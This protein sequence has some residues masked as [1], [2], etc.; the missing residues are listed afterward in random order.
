MNPLQ[1]DGLRAQRYL[2]ALETIGISGVPK[3]TIV[4]DDRGYSAQAASALGTDYL[5]NSTIIL[6]PDQLSAGIGSLACGVE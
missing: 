5:A 3:G 1:L 6:H 4:I 2:S